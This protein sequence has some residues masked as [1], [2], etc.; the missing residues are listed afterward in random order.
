MLLDPQPPATGKAR[1]KLWAGRALV[2]VL[3][4]ASTA[5]LLFCPCDMPGRD[6]RSIFLAA[7]SLAF[8]GIAV[9]FAYRELQPRRDIT[10][11]LKVLIA[12]AVVAAGVF[13]Q[14]TVA[15]DIIA[16]LARPR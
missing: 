5:A 10:A 2:F 7:L 14:F 4:S 9:V 16:W 13:A 3:I 12:S 11:F 15:T 6:A 8:A 1:R